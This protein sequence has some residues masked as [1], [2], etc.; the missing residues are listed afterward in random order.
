MQ[1][2]T[3]KLLLGLAI[4]AIV[5]TVA[6][7]Q[8][9]SRQKAQKTQAAKVALQD[10]E[11]AIRNVD[12][13]VADIM[14]P[15]KPEAATDRSEIINRFAAALV[16]AKASAPK[17][18]F[19]AVYFDTRLGKV[20]DKTTMPKIGISYA[21]HD[22]YETPSED[23][24]AYWAGKAGFDQDT[25]KYFKV[26]ISQ[27]VA[28][29]AVDGVVV[30]EGD[31]KAEF[32]YHFSRGDHLVEVRFFNNWHTTD[33]A[34]SIVNE[35]EVQEENRHPVSLPIKHSRPSDP[36][37][38]S[39]QGLAFLPQQSATLSVG[40]LSPE[41]TANPPQLL[42]VG[43]YKSTLP[44][45]SVT[46]VLNKAPT[47]LILMLDGGSGVHWV[48]K[49]PANTPIAKVIHSRDTSVSLETPV[50]IPVEAKEFPSLTSFRS[51]D[52]SCSCAGAYFH[53]ENRPLLPLINALQLKTGLP[54]YGY[55]MEYEAAMVEAP[56][57]ILAGTLKNLGGQLQRFRDESRQCSA[58]ASPNFDT[59]LDA[60]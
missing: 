4:G 21:W 56:K 55:T 38:E 15:S 49:N 26:D 34:V 52:L 6:Y 48:I 17:G 60:F 1:E 3:R 45:S 14:A 40:S 10:N 23:F 33:L 50:P 58:K 16:S 5:G 2:P 51:D 46:V 22:Q 25:L 12:K 36:Y 28:R 42:L 20:L 24:G 11:A 32:P 31:E 39:N 57:Q 37:E 8:V 35:D 30:Y 19:N 41:F 13:M 44:D 54:V 59:M 27:G 43:I 53:C 47:P 9:D 18:E 7:Y 29:I